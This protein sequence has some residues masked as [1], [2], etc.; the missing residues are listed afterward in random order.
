MEIL[1]LAA[2]IVQGG[3]PVAA[4]IVCYVLWRENKRVQTRFEIMLD[5]LIDREVITPQE[6]TDIRQE[7]RREKA[8]RELRSESLKTTKEQTPP[9]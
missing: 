7:I 6:A 8:K 9:T 3:L 4:L 2:I 1:E 5:N